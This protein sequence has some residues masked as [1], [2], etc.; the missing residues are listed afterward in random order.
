VCRFHHPSALQDPGA[1]YVA[2][3]IAKEHRPAS[4]RS[5]WCL[6]YRL[7]AEQSRS[8]LSGDPVVTIRPPRG[9]LAF[10]A[11]WI[12]FLCLLMVAGAVGEHN[13]RGLFLVFVWLPWLVPV[14]LAA[15]CQVTAIGDTLTYRSSFRI[16][17]WHRSQVQRFEITPLRWS[18]RA[19]QIH[20]H[21][22]GGQSVAFAITTAH[23]L[24]GT[25]QIERW[26]TALEDWRNGTSQ[27]RPS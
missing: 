27:S 26:C 6:A 12:G 11:A 25:A 3:R 2:S 5:G 23:W 17:S 24:R 8:V 13:A 9:G 15:R 10:M 21:T 22:T 20:M 7:P 14:M 1:C 16:R 4:G 19:N 18:Y